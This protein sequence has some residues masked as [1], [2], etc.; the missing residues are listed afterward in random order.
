MLLGL[1]S[2]Y[3]GGTTYQPETGDIVFQSLP[4]P[5]GLDLVDAIEGA[6]GS[7]YSHCAMV[8]EENGQW[9]VIEAI[10]P[11]KVTS[12]KEYTARGRGGKIWAY[13]FD[14]AGRKYVP[15]ALATMRKDL[16]KPYDPRYRFDDQAIYCSELIWRGWKSATG[17]GLGNTV[18]LGSLG[19]KPYQPVIEAIEGRGNLPLDREM[20]TPRDL[21]KAPQLTRIFPAE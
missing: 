6:T 5:P 21:A 9:Q 1:V 18:T 8:F 3:G 12:L 11:V 4:N 13:R 15:A 17:K 19:W 2:C 16:G 20:I 10:G 14:Q 7:P